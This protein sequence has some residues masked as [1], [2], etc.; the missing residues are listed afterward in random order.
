MTT[1]FLA[2]VWENFFSKFFKPF[3]SIHS[4][5]YN[6]V[7]SIVTSSIAS[8]WVSAYFIQWRQPLTWKNMWSFRNGSHSFIIIDVCYDGNFGL[9]FLLVKNYK[10]CLS[11]MPLSLNNN[12]HNFPKHNKLLLTIH[13]NVEKFSKF[14]YL[15]VQSLN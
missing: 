10:N 5:K 9:G 6:S 15:F 12:P 3:L 13:L 14:Q 1:S 2:K 8:K 4:S 11:F 7:E